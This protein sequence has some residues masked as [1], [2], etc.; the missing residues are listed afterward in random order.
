MPSGCPLR[1]PRHAAPALGVPR[2]IP[3][4]ERPQA[5][6]GPSFFLWL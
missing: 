2:R 3:V 4:A 6:G 5:A 1:Q